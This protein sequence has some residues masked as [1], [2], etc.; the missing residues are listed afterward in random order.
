MWKI[1]EKERPFLDDSPVVV[2]GMNWGAK[3]FQ[4]QGLDDIEAQIGWC[5]GRGVVMHLPEKDFQATPGESNRVCTAK[6]RKP[7]AGTNKNY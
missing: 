1:I 2:L 7:T 3:N 4:S 6:P 5:W